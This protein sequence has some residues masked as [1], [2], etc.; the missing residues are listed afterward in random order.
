MKTDSA[1]NPIESFN[2]HCDCNSTGGCYKCRPK[3]HTKV[4]I[5]TENNK[6]EELEI[7]RII[8]KANY[9]NII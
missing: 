8:N 2:I 5:I 4:Q 1:G 6:Q 9:G 7:E 3:T